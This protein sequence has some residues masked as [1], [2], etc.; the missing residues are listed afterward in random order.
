MMIPIKADLK[1][2][3][4]SLIVDFPFDNIPVLTN[5]SDWE[6]WGTLLIESNSFAVNAAPPTRGYSDWQDW[7]MRVYKVMSNF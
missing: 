2:W 5:E 7:A 3:A 4:S 6:R 1:T